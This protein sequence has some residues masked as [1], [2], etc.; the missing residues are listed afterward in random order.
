MIGCDVANTWSCKH[1]GISVAMVHQFGPL[2]ADVTMGPSKTWQAALY[3]FIAALLG[4]SVAAERGWLHEIS[5]AL[6]KNRPS[7]SQDR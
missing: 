2:G 5:E 4:L 6:D 3:A 1:R 7:Q